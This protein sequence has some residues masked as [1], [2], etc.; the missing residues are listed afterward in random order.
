MNQ[1]ITA[2][3]TSFDTTQALE[4]I[5]QALGAVRED[6]LP[7]GDRD[8]DR[9]WD[10]ITTCMAWITE[11]LEEDDTQDVD[12]SDWVECDTVTDA[13][14]MEYISRCPQDYE[15]VLGYL[16]RYN[17]WA[18]QADLWDP[19]ATLRDGFWCKHRA[20]ERGIEVVKVDAPSVL[21]AEG[22]YAVNAYPLCLLR[23]R[24]GE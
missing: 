9:Q 2:R 18:L 1:I 5:W 23:E 10:E 15:T 14:R 12:S 19:E 24:L 11:A 6:L 7:E 4:V 21:E 13:T 22:I 3:A 8:Y 20:N 16:A 17:P